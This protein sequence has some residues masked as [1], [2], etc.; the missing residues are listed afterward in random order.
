MMTATASERTGRGR[1]TAASSRRTS[2]PKKETSAKGESG[3]RR[4]AHLDL[5][6][7]SADFRAPQLR[8]P[9]VPTPREVVR[10]AGSATKLL[11]PRDQMLYYGGLGAAAVVGVIEWPVAIA[12]GAGL[13]IVQRSRRAE[14]DRTTRKRSESTES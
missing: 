11:P 14:G 3:R 13:A 1:K 7:V 5:P 6:L 12:V 10:T 8:M 4:T 9:H 2:A